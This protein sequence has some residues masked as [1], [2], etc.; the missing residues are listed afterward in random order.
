MERC[1]FGHFHF[2]LENRL[3]A[4]FGGRRLSFE[5]WEHQSPQRQIKI[6]LLGSK[7]R[8]HQ[9]QALLLLLLVVLFVSLV[10]PKKQRTPPTRN[11]EHQQQRATSN[12]T[13]IIGEAVVRCG[14]RQFV[15]ILRGRWHL[16][17]KAPTTT[18]SNFKQQQWR[19]MATLMNKMIA[20]GSDL[21]VFAVGG[22]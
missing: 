7:Q 1:S 11:K 18:A 21:L 4:K 12:N 5:N 14:G 13:N 6:L 16:P 8:Q 19:T 22:S 2:S 17:G 3:L 9:T 10:L 15:A 20:G